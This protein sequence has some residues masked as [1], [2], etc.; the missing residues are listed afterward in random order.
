MLEISIGKKFTPLWHSYVENAF[1]R[2]EQF[3]LG[4]ALV[5]LKLFLFRQLVEENLMNCKNNRVC[6]GR[7][8]QG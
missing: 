4:S 5:T 1:L 8:D 7:N 2:N 6:S 3:S